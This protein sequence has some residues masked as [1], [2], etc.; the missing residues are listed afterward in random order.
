MKVSATLCALSN[1]GLP[2]HDEPS[3]P[4]LENHLAGPVNPVEAYL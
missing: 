4:G 1:E 2:I 3:M